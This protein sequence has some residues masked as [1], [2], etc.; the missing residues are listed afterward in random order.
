[1]IMMSA[2]RIIQ[3]SAIVVFFAKND[4]GYTQYVPW[5][6]AGQAAENKHWLKKCIV[7]PKLF[8]ISDFQPFKLKISSLPVT[9]F[10]VKVETDFG[11]LAH[12]NSEL[13]AGT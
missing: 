12:F 4:K 7:F 8:A 3:L 5:W 9:P 6:L 10:L 13:V 11:F 2:T 1:M